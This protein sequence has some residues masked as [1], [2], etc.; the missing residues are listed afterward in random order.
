HS[1]LKT[2]HP[3]RSAIHKQL[4][5]RLVLRWVTTWES[6]LLYVLLFSLHTKNFLQNIMKPIVVTAVI[7]TL[8]AAV[9]PRPGSSDQP[10]TGLA[11]ATRHKERPCY[12][13]CKHHCLK[14]YSVLLTSPL[15]APFVVWR[16]KHKCR[17]EC[18]YEFHDSAEAGVGGLD[19]DNDEDAEGDEVD[20][21][22]SGDAILDLVKAN[23]TIHFDI[24]KLKEALD[25]D[26][27]D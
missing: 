6:L 20:G 23:G 4:N 9:P 26:M 10:A 5:G 12:H 13:Q 24:E 17:K 14:V 16:C 22:N 18:D 8:V 25:M 3:V 7:T 19:A 27:V 2:G 21:I 1:Q 15:T 11:V